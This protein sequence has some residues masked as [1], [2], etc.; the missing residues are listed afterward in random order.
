VM[1]VG[2]ALAFVGLLLSPGLKASEG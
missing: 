2:S 1:Y